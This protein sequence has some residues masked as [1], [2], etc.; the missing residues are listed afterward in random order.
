MEDREKKKKDGSKEI[1]VHHTMKE[2]VHGTLKTLLDDF[3]DQ[4]KKKM[5]KHIHNKK[6]QYLSLRALKENID[7]DSIVL[8]IDL[9]ENYMCKFHNEI[10]AVHFGDSHQQVSLHTGVA[11]TMNGVVSVCTIS[12][13]MRHDPSAIWAHLKK[14][15]P[16][17]KQLNAAATTLHVISDGPTTQYRSKNNFFFLS[18]VPYELG[19]QNV[20]WIFLEAGHGKGAAVKR[21][22]D[23]LVAKGINLPTG[24]VLFEQLINQPSTV[25]LMSITDGEIEEMDRLLPDGLLTIK[26]TMQIHQVS[27][28]SPL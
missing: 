23:S 12:S 20:T 27:H 8:Q 18:K 28:M 16:Y 25:K 10:Q 22:A 2:K 7:K 5:G 14:V 1:K 11:H 26:G 15:L 4:L 24:K 19:F 6:H 9:A 3:S 21:Q 17:L 13:S